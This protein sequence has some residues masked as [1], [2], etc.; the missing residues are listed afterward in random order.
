MTSII[1]NQI[2]KHLSKFARNITPDQISVQILSGKGELKNIELNEMVL[3]EALEL[4]VWLRIKRAVCN[5]I[6]V[7]V[8]WTRLKSQPVQ[9][10]IDEIQV[11]VE[12]SSKEVIYCGSN[13]LSSLGDLSY[14][15]AN[16]VAEGMSLY[17]NSVEIHF[18]SGIFRGSLTL[19]RLAVESKSPN[20]Q[21]TNDLRLTRIVDAANNR[22]LMFKMVTWQLLRIE[23]SAQDDLSGSIIN[24]PLR[25]ITS[26]GKSRISVKKST[27]DGSVIGGRIQVILDNIL[28]IA[29]LPQ[30]RSAI[31][32]YDHIINI[33]RMAPK[34]ASVVQTQRLDLKISSG[35]KLSSSNPNSNIFRSFDFEQ[36]SYHVYVGK[37]D[38]HL[39]DDNQSSDGYPK[40]WDIIS[41]ALQV[42]MFR[43]SV[44]FY[45]AN[46]A[47]LDRSDW[48]RYDN[49]NQCALWFHKVLQSHLRKLCNELD[50]Q[51]QTQVV[52]KWPSLLSQN[53]VIR[54]YDVIVQCVTD[55]STK[56][57]SLFNLFMLDRKSKSS[58]PNDHPLFHLE[59]ASF[60]HPLSENFPV[61]S[62]VTHLLLGPFFFLFD[63]RTIRWLLFVFN[64]IRCALKVS[65]AVPEIVKIPKTSLRID[66]IMSKIIVP[67]I[68]PSV[69][70]TR[71][72][73]R[74]VINMNSL[75]ATNSEAVF[76]SES[77]SFFKS[78]S[79]N[80]IDYIDSTDLLVKKEKLKE[81]IFK[82]N[83]N[84]CGGDNQG[85]RIWISTSPIWVETD[86]GEKTPSS[87][88]VA[89]VDFHICLNLSA[90]KIS[91]A[92]QPMCNFRIAIDHFQFLQFMRLISCVS[93]FVDQTI[94]DQKWFSPNENNGDNMTIDI[95]CFF[96]E[97]EI[98]IILPNQQMPNPYVLAET[99]LQSPTISTDG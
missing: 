92:L 22:L 1:K 56:K 72:A 79:P 48:L 83:Q 99:V 5:R 32:F 3:S 74:I 13:L 68:Q 50:A 75:V 76:S 51:T 11:E 23:A 66:L 40:D 78:I 21:S 46:G 36:T 73:R 26:S 10:F 58:M 14:G 88:F 90:T 33:I 44:D 4:P 16:R 63:Q 82:L 89:D 37:I 41:G 12:L 45:P 34:K 17:V 29:T 64:D 80:V 70:D 19:S 69:P 55:L 18:D 2:I 24:A 49:A 86:F 84:S 96:E 28:W 85:E 52:S 71:F 61:P 87:P 25:L 39:C 95:V 9:L 98:N 20:W 65:G 91:V 43:L 94:S 57:E 31:A 67:L 30:V 62:S 47:V 53:C 97:I 7:K 81:F 6:A 35:S 38:L 8:P 42:T 77:N 54:I 60:Y 59:L 27:C 93:T 15:F